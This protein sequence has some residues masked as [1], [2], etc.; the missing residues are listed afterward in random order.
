MLLSLLIDELNH[1]PK[2]DT[3]SFHNL[4]FLPLQGFQLILQRSNF[5]SEA[6]HITLLWRRIS[7][8]CF[9]RSVHGV[10]HQDIPI[11]PDF[12]SRPLQRLTSLHQSELLLELQVGPLGLFQLRPQALHGLLSLLPQADFF[13]QSLS[14]LHPRG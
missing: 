2:L 3:R 9:F 5:S 12:D 8:L 1:L 6:F 4:V 10:L 7:I 11:A 14:I 13:V